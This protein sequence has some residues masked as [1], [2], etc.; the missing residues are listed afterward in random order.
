MTFTSSTRRKSSSGISSNGVNT[1]TA[2]VLTQASM[3]PNRSTARRVA[4]STAAASVTSAGA[5]TASPGGLA[6]ARHVVESTLASRDEDD[7]G[8]AGGE[9]DRRRAPN[10]A[11]GAGDDHNRITDAHGP[12]R[13]AGEW[14]KHR[15]A[16]GAA[17]GTTCAW[18]ARHA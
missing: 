3:R 12:W 2:A 11:R 9:R 6:L 13:P 18:V 14:S 17:H 15:V 1:L 5:T 4:A 16:P 7:G 10:P 8:A